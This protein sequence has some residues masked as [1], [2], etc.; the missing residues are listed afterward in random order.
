MGESPGCMCVEEAGRAES[1][2]QPEAG[3]RDVEAVGSE[4]GS[5]GREHRTPICAR[6]D[7]SI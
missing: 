7:G 2:L 1:R 4:D 6:K 5:E 3:E